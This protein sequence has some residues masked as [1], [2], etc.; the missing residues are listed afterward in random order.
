MSLPKMLPN[1]FNYTKPKVDQYVRANDSYMKIL[2]IAGLITITSAIIK[3]I[4]AY[5][6][7]K[8]EEKLAKM[9]HE[10]KMLALE[11]ERIRLEKEV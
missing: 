1:D 10:E 6:E 11:I 7:N 3:T 8:H 2:G 5:N 9:E 4:Q